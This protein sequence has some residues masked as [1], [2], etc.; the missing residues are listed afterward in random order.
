MSR[1]SASFPSFGGTAATW[2]VCL[3]FFQA[4][5]LAGY[6]YAHLMRRLIRPTAQR[7][8]H[9]LVSI[10]T[11]IALPASATAPGTGLVPALDPTWQVLSTLAALIGAPYLLLSTTSPLIQAWYVE[12][13]AIDASRPIPT[14]LYALSNT[15]SFIALI[16][17]PILNEPNLTL[18]QQIEGSVRTL[19]VVYIVAL[20]ILALRTRSI[21]ASIAATST[22]RATELR[23]TFKRRLL[24]IALLACSSTLLMAV[25][26]Q[27]TQ[28]VAPVPFIWVFLLGVYLL[29]F[30]ICFGL[31]LR[32][33]NG[34]HGCGR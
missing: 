23:P 19:Y 11:L 16:S 6:L 17:Y 29:G 21:V 33:G 8:V 31:Q 7:G 1:A 32:A 20:V 3:L 12:S 27:V 14:S 24:W 26:N 30:V 2:S 5:L 9:V 13:H 22:D 34:R 10:L 25:T 18:H 4:L 15:G 28:N